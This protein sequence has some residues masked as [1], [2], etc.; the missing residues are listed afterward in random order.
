MGVGKDQAI[1]Q[2]GEI[3]VLHLMVNT[4]SS[5]AW[6]WANL[7]YRNQ[8]ISV[9]FVYGFGLRVFGTLYIPCN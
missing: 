3:V 9:G 1:N 2:G 5:W 6:F 8:E 4:L 7:N